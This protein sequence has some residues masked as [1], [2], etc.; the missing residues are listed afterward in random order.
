VQVWRLDGIENLP[1]DGP[2]GIF[3]QLGGA[4]RADPSLATVRASIMAEWK[5]PREAVGD[6]AVKGQSDRENEGIPR[7]RVGDLQKRQ[8]QG[9]NYPNGGYGQAPPSPVYN[10]PPAPIPSGRG[11][12]ANAIWLN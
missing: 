12:C 10:A 11:C 9:Y 3:Q 6:P 7:G 2:R 5:A 8:Q 1:R 4:G